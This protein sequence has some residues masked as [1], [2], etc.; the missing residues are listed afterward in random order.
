MS[1]SNLQDKVVVISGANG[2]LGQVCS[3][4]F[5]EAGAKLALLGRKQSE[6]D[7]LA[8]E[9]GLSAGRFIALEQDVSNFEGNQSAAKT[10]Q[11]ELGSLDVF[12]NLVGGWTGGKSVLETPKKDFESMIAQHVHIS[13]AQIKAFL[14]PMLEKSWGRILAISSPSA[15]RPPGMNSP[16][17]VGKAGMQ[18]LMLSLAQ[19]LEGSG[20]TANLLQVN[21]IDVDHQRIKNRSEKNANWTTPEEISATLLHL[22]NQEAGMINGARIPVFGSF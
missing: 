16:Y 10:I 1:Q 12:I 7:Q 13:L 21:T 5:A 4:T 9:L 3:R 11:A 6:L 2:G 15:D 14:P 18:A 17:A 20:V 22:C 8:K 19:E